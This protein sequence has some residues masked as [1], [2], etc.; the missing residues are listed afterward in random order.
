VLI[1]RPNIFGPEPNEIKETVYQ[2]LHYRLMAHTAEDLCEM[3]M[4]QFDRERCGHDD[5]R[6]GF[7]IYFPETCPDIDIPALEAQV[8]SVIAQNLPVGYVDDNHISVGDRVHKCNGPR[9]HVHRTGQIEN[10]RLMHHLIYDRF[11]R[12]YVLV[13]CVGEG[14]EEILK[15]L[16]NQRQQPGWD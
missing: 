13:G 1:A 8:K 12:R 14:A 9:I 7:A 3:Y 15:R 10:F 16:D 6:H 2:S 4:N 5:V 11:K